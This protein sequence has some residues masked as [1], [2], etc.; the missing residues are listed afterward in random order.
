MHGW[1]HFASSHGYRDEQAIGPDAT[2]FNV[3]STDRQGNQQLHHRVKSA[4]TGGLA[5]LLGAMAH[6]KRRPN[7]ALGEET[8]KAF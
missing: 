2:E 3:W 7:S 5:G 4:V 8:V 6:K 1:H